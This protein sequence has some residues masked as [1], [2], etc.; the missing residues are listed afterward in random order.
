MHLVPSA[1]ES[2]SRTRKSIQPVFADVKTDE[3]DD[4]HI[5]SSVEAIHSLKDDKYEAV[6]DDFHSSVEQATKYEAISF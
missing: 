2:A 6:Q 5:N 3:E 4:F 1:I